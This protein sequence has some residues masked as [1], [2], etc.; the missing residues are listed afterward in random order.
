MPKKVLEDLTGKKYYEWTVIERGPNSKN[1]NTR[2]KC[3]CSCGKIGLV[4]SSDLKSGNHKSCGRCHFHVF[5]QDSFWGEI[6]KQAARRGY[7]FKITKD[8]MTELWK[9][10]DGKCALSGEIL[11]MPE[12]AR[13]QRGPKCTAS[14][15]RID[16]SKGYVIGNVQWILKIINKMR[17][18]FTI[19]EYVEVC[20][21]VSKYQE[22]NK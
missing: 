22:E 21:K 12:K 18:E 16:N 9:S 3:K 11:H 7:E 6:K 20:K 5:I 15:D 10:Q 14:I 1:K 17:R 19:E 4:L 13:E 2:W 8:Y